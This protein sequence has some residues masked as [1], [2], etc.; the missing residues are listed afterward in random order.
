MIFKR[1]I[2]QGR[3]EANFDITNIETIIEI[4]SELFQEIYSSNSGITNLFYSCGLP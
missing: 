4:G 1:K 2:S 3:F